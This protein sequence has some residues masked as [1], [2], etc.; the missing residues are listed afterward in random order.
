MIYISTRDD[1]V[2]DEA[3]TTEELVTKVADW[4]ADGWVHGDRKPPEYTEIGRLSDD[5]DQL[6][7]DDRELARFNADVMEAFDERVD[8]PSDY[9]EHNTHYCA[10]QF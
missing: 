2:H 6:P 3:L 8:Q 5:G 4:Y 7:F 10:A 1:T 9:E